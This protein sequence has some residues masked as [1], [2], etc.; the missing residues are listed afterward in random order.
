MRAAARARVE[1]HARAAAALLEPA[2]GRGLEIVWCR[3]LPPLRGY[4]T[5]ALA[6]TDPGDHWILI[7]ETL[8]RTS[9]ADE[10]EDTIRHEIAHVVAWYRYGTRIADHGREWAR[11][12]QSLDAALAE[13]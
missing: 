5:H 3:E 2:V 7:N 10:R 13:E 11:T 1:R 4:T 8:W 12:R 6:W 9:S